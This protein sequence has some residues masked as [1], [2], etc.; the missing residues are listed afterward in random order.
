M[1]DYQ[2]RKLVDILPAP[3]VT[4]QSHS[5]WRIWTAIA[6]GVLLMA[7]WLLLRSRRF[8][9]FRLRQQ[10]IRQRIDHREAAARLLKLSQINDKDLQRQL[11]EIRF[12]P[13]SASTEELLALLRRMS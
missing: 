12:G 2:S 9:W 4:V 1:N 3:D 8:A 6:V 11:L 5:D 13:Q 10:I 7:C